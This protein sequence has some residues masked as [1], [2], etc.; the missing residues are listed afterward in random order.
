MGDSGGP[1][2]VEQ[3]GKLIQ[4]GVASAGSIG[5]VSKHNI[6]KDHPWAACGF[7]PDMYTPVS[8]IVPWMV[9]L[10]KKDG[11]APIVQD[12]LG[13]NKAYERLVHTQR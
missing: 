5:I 4:I 13:T 2:V 10:M 7:A 1:L 11:E 9:E 6:T 12:L 3:N 8:A